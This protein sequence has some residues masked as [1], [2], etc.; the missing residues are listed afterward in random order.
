MKTIGE[1]ID[2]LSR[3][4]GVFSEIKVR[5]IFTRWESVVGPLLA[6]KTK[7][8]SLSRGVLTVWCAES[9]WAS[10]LKFYTKD[11]LA[12]MKEQLRDVR[13]IRSIKIVYK[14]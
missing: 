12:K 6:E 10:E 2:G 1:V 8:V 3:K 11:I 9:V 7:P 5:T 14:E 4:K 13:D